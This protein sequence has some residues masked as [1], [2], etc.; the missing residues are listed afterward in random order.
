MA[1]HPH[2]IHGSQSACL[3]KRSTSAARTPVVVVNSIQIE[4]TL[5][6]YATSLYKTDRFPKERR[7]GDERVRQTNARRPSTFSRVEDR[8]AINRAAVTKQCAG[9][10]MSWR[11]NPDPEKHHGLIRQFFLSYLLEHPPRRF[12]YFFYCCQ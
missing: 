12:S 4:V 1:I 5:E 6:D 7:H 9:T 10:H 11:F 2:V 3:R 8:G